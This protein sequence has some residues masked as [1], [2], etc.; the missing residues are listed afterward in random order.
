MYIHWDKVY[1]VRFSKG[2]GDGIPQFKQALFIYMFMH[3]SEVVALISY[4]ITNVKVA[5][6]HYVK[7]YGLKNLVSNHQTIQEQT[8][9]IFL[10]LSCIC[11]NFEELVLELG[12]FTDLVTHLVVHC[13]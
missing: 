11:H 3:F 10:K 12:S 7:A 6:R 2:K 9:S 13:H 5:Y 4:R 8:V 1:F